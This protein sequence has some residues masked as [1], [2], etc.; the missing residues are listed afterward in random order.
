MSVVNSPGP[1]M[2][3]R[4]RTRPRTAYDRKGLVAV[5]SYELTNKAALHRNPAWQFGRDKNSNFLMKVQKDSKGKPGP[6]SYEIKS[7]F[8]TP[9]SRA[10][11][12]LMS[13]GG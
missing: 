8:S 2:S 3:G 5:P 12:G 7:Q 13:S 9:K 6:G 11:K 4:R 10:S 1:K